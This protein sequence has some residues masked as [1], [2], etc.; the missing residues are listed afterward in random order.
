[1]SLAGT[2]RAPCRRSSSTR[3]QFGAAAAK[4]R[5]DTPQTPPF[6]SACCS[7]SIVAILAKQRILF[8]ASMSSLPKSRAGATVLLD[9]L[10]G[11][12]GEGQEERS[13]DVTVGT[14]DSDAYADDLVCERNIP[15]RSSQVKL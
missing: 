10:I 5:G 4:Q 12:H 1:M 3:G 14:V 11:K 8:N 6:T 2:G 7:M 9:L 15:R 13:D